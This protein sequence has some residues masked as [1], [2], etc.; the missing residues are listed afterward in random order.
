[1]NITNVF[2][3]LNDLASMVNHDCD[4]LK[5]WI[6]DEVRTPQ[7]LCRYM[8]QILSYM[9]VHKNV[10]FFGCIWS[11]IFFFQHFEISMKKTITTLFLWNLFIFSV[12]ITWIWIYIFSIIQMY[13]P[14]PISISSKNLCVFA[15]TRNQ[16]RIYRP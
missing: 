9:R 5:I 1:M 12:H 11:L 6:Q 2:G 7:V 13:F 14:K 15:T 3:N 10:W 8:E 16:R 4:M